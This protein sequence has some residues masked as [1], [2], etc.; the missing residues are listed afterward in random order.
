MFPI[1]QMGKP[2]LKVRD[3]LAGTRLLDGTDDSQM[4]VDWKELID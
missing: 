1:V 4:Q 3:E 2:R